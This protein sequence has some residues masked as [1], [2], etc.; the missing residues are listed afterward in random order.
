MHAL[1]IE[2]AEVRSCV[3]DTS[4]AAGVSFRTVRISETGEVFRNTKLRVEMWR[5][6]MAGA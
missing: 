6:G 3:N 4:R 1:K 5:S 2:Q